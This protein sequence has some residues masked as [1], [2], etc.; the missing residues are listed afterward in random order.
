MEILVALAATVPVLVVV[1]V[2]LLAVR[3]DGYGRRTPPASHA[4]WSAEHLP[5]RA[6]REG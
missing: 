2:L 5:S 3:G 1:A 6:Y 4:D